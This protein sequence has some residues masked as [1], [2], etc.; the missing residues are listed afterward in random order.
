MSQNKRTAVHN[1]YFQEYAN[2]PFQMYT[3]VQKDRDSNLD[4]SS[5]RKTNREILENAFRKFS[6]ILKIQNA[7]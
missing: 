5:V 4:L 1:N 7:I 2:F 3:L 6:L